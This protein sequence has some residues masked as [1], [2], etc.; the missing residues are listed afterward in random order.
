MH[1]AY[2]KARLQIT[3]ISKNAGQKKNGFLEKLHVE[4]SWLSYLLS[5]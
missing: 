1:G 5:L 2:V 3:K 4:T